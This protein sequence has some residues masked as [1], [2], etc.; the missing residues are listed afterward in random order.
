MQW[1]ADGRL[2]AAWDQTAL[3]VAKIHNAHYTKPVQPW[4]IGPYALP[5]A[6]TDL[7]LG[8]LAEFFKAMPGVTVTETERPEP[9]KG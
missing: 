4:E 6:Q 5:R 8:D 3:L 7:E 9:E 1:A 2:R